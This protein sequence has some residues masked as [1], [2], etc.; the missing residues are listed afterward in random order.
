MHDLH[1]FGVRKSRLHAAQVLNRAEHQARAD[2]QHERERHLHH[3]QRVARPMAFP[4]VAERP[5]DTTQRGRETGSCVF[6]NGHDPE[7]HARE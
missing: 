6:H 2:Q 1:L 5:A 7:E 4:A 3:D